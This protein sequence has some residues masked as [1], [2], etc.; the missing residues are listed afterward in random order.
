VNIVNDRFENQP[1]GTEGEI[2]LKGENVFEGYWNNP[3]ANEK[4]FHDGWFL[5]GDIGSIDENGYVYII[6]RKKDI[7]KSGGL[8][9]YPNEIESVIASI[10]GVKECA[11]VGIPDEQYGESIKACIVAENHLV[12]ENEIIAFCKSNL[13]SFKKPKKV[14]F[15]TALPRNAMGKILKEELRKSNSSLY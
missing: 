2:I 10:P 15:L 11:V 1:P 12:S 14:E 7:I 8:L 5:T 9:I 4:S 3:E 6:G 13:A